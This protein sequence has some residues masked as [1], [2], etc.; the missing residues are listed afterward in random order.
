MNR[1]DDIIIFESLSNESLKE[2]VSIQLGL[3]KKRLE[4]KNIKLLFKDAVIER[5]S[6]DGKDKDYGARPIKRSIQN[7]VED[8]LSKKI[9]SNEINSGD[10]IEIDSGEIGEL[11][12][13]KC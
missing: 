11:I 2:I 6:K 13:K 1:I 5:I 8:L 7:L 9:L 12:I 3:L 4:S 10:T